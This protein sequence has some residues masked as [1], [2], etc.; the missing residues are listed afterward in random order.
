MCPSLCKTSCGGS[1][2]RSLPLSFP[3]FLAV[4]PL[5]PL[6]LYGFFSSVLSHKVYRFLKKVSV[7]TLKYGMVVSVFMYTDGHPE[8]SPAHVLQGGKQSLST[9]RDP[10]SCLLCES[11]SGQWSKAGPSFLL[12]QRPHRGR[13]ERKQ[14]VEEQTFF[15]YSEEHHW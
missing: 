6:R 14:G 5:C 11:G 4:R 12:L 10:C 9:R 7:L 2:C 8:S 3:T 15:H 13:T 1:C